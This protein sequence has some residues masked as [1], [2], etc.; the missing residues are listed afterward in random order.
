MIT[1]KDLC[2]L[3]IMICCIVMTIALGKLAGYW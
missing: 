3:I 1:Y 2:L